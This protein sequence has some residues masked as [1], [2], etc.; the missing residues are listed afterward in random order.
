MAFP[1][2]YRQFI[3]TIPDEIFFAYAEA[4]AQAD[5]P[6]GLLQRIREADG[7]DIEFEISGQLVS[8]PCLIDCSDILD[9]TAG[10]QGPSGATQEIV[11]AVEE[12]VT[13]DVGFVGT[14]VCAQLTIATQ[15]LYPHNEIEAVRAMRMDDGP[16]DTSQP[17]RGV[18]EFTGA[19][20]DPHPGW[21]G[22][23]LPAAPVFYT[24]H[25]GPAPTCAYVG[26]GL[27]VFAQTHTHLKEQV[28]TAWTKGPCEGDGVNYY[29]L[30]KTP[31][32]VKAFKL[33]YVANRGTL[34]WN[35][36]VP[37][38]YLDFVKQLGVIRA[39]DRRWGPPPG[40]DHRLEPV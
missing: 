4:F 7:E 1:M 22:D 40:S 34:L 36:R 5:D 27:V 3:D 23:V 19:T 38:G 29:Q 39:R 15:R 8:M 9:G 12:H 32:G 2:S 6:V 31:H 11:E 18:A 24:G 25:Y 35:G 26:D 28:R 30:A 20:S 17:Y 21:G 14:G 16:V 13:P 37:L 33:Q 10:T